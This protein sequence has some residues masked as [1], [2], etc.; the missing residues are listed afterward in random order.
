M[1]A[2]N[3]DD[4]GLI[5]RNISGVDSRNL[6]DTS[7]SFAGQKL[8]IP[9]IASPMPDVCDGKMAMVLSKL[10]SYGFIH[11]F[12]SIDEQI[13]EYNISEGNCGVAIGINGDYVERFTSLYDWGCRSFCIDVANGANERV[14]ETVIKLKSLKEDV[15]L[16][17]GN[18]ATLECFAWLA[19]LPIYAIRVGISGGSACTTRTETGLFYPMA[20]SLLECSS[21][22]NRSK[23]RPIIIADGNIKEPQDMCKALVLGAD[24]GMS[25]SLFA[26]SEESPASIMKIN[27]KLLKTYKGA[28]S[29][30][31]QKSV[32]KKPE[33]VEGL[34]SLIPYTG[35][36]EKTIKRFRNGLKSSMSY[37][38]ALTLEEYK[39]NAGWVEID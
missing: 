6:V 27:G 16:T 11:R 29:F 14:K 26:A 4:I 10:G 18:V 23:N 38:N 20:S 21:Y 22:S 36:V 33:Y 31:T 13:N 15:F 39:K 24:L 17:V 2:L 5:S 37:M 25:G 35:S 1:Y 3:Y 9:L 28:A 7:L 8:S 32:G 34:E 30:S 19:Q 12:N